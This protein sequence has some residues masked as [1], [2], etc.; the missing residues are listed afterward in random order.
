ME[1][2]SVL[3][4]ILINLVNLVFSIK[5]MNRIMRQNWKDFM[6]KF[7]LM[8]AIRFIIILGIFFVLIKIIKMDELYL[9]LT[10]IL[11][12]FVVIIIEILYLNKRYSILNFKQPKK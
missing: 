2:I 5:Y 4:A 7:Y 11:S 9:S 3:I 1:I 10:F 6:K 8:M 12:Y